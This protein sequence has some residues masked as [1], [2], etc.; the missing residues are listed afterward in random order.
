MKRIFLTG[1]TGFIGSHIAEYFAA[2]GVDCS[3][4]VR[5]TRTADVLRTLPV[6]IVEGDILHPEN[7]ADSLVAVDTIVHV[8]GKVSDWGSWQDFYTS[9]VIGTLNIMQAA[10]HTGVRHVILTGSNA[11]YGEE[12]SSVVKTEES[13]HAPHYPYF[14]D[15]IFP[16]GLNHYRDSKALACSEATEFATHY[17]LDL[18]IIE[19][20]WVYGERELHTGFFDFLKTVQSGIPLFPGSSKNR[21]HTIYVRDLARLYFLAFEARLAGVHR[22]LACDETAEKQRTL[23]DMFCREAGLTLPR[24]LPRAVVYPPA[25]IME[26]AATLLHRPRSPMLT[27]AIVNI[28]YDNIEYSSAKAQRVLGFVPEYTREESI[29]RTVAWYKE[30]KLL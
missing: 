28:F 25:L 10:L 7:L 19:P 3:C 5:D 26:A 9:N 24:A 15:S 14:L 11:T 29:R 30:R 6:R 1:G 13:L 8:A 12:N 2:Q 22:F 17:G 23:F 18:T 21:F 20:V 27:R 16:S 4:L